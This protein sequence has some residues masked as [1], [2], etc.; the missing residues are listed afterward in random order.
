MI[1]WIILA[2]GALVFAFCVYN[3]CYK[4]RHVI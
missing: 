4:K 3:N 2:L 1:V